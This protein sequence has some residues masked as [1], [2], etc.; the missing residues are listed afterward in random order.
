MKL[1]VKNV[2]FSYDSVPAL[3]DIN[4][5]VE[6][7]QILS[8]VGP[9]GSGKSTLLKCILKILKPKEGVILINGRDTIKMKAKEM[10]NLSGYVPQ[11]G[12]NAFSLTVF[13]AVLM[14][15]RPHLSWK[16]SEEDIEIV[17]QTLALMGIEEFAFRYLNELSGGEKQKVLIARA[18]AQEPELIL[19]DEP[20]NNLDLRHQLE[21]MEIIV[22]LVRQKRISVIMTMHDLNLA[23]KYTSMIVMLNRGKIFAA[24]SPKSVFT[25]ENIESVYGVEVVISYES[26]QPN[27][28]PIRPIE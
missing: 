20:T 5:E 17:S 6:E 8:I 16:A 3:A 11:G 10:A 19:L 4:L 18:I 13:D 1:T 15:R 23:S 22:D 28:I 21:V 25:R 2:T 26:G 27:L 9:N 14:G 7:A 12:D 24:G